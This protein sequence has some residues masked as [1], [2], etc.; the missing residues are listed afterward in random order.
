MIFFFF[1]LEVGGG[2]FICRISV[3]FSFWI[4][5]LPDGGGRD[6]VMSC[7]ESVLVW[8][9]WP[10]REMRGERGGVTGCCFRFC[11]LIMMYTTLVRITPERNESSGCFMPV[12]YRCVK[13][14]M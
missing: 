9:A 11:L 14:Q 13:M 10:G 5:E 4:L 8:L 3:L 6:K 7:F 2:L 1:F 12:L